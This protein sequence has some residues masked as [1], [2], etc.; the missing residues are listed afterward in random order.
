MS[1]IWKNSTKSGLCDRLLDLF[2]MASYSKLINKK[3]FLKWEEQPINKIQEKVWNPTR[4][5]D[6]KIVNLKKYFTLP[7]HIN[8]TYTKFLMKFTPLKN[9]LKII[10]NKTYNFF[11]SNYK[12]SLF[13]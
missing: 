2:I 1:L 3:I 10:L 6:Y 7:E 5:D 4:F 8:I 13:L 9:N 12:S 11:Y